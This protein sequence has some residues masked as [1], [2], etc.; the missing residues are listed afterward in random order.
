MNETFELETDYIPLCD[1]LKYCA[2]TDTGG[3]AKYL[4]SLGDVMVDGEVETRKTC[5]I[6][7]GQVVTGDGFEIH[8][9]APG[10]A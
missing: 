6:R 9:V 1:L 10:S 4:I 8:V 7:A 2:V 3:Q 5:K